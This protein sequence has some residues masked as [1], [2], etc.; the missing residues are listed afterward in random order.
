MATG[1]YLFGWIKSWRNS[2]LNGELPSHSQMGL[3]SKPKFAYTSPHANGG[4]GAYT[5]HVAGNF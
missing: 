4:Y 3:I 5:D 2:I 1:T